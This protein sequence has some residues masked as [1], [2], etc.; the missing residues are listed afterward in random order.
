MRWYPLLF[1]MLAACTSTWQRQQS[2]LATDEADEQ[3]A[4]AAADARWLIDNAF[5]EAPAADR[6]PSAEAGRYL[7]LAKLSAKAGDIRAAVDALRHALRV[8]PQQGAAVRAELA[9]LPLPPAQLDRLKREFAWNSAALAPGDDAD[10]GPDHG[11][12]CWSYRVHEVQ[13][14][15]RRTLRTVDGLQRQVTYDARPWRFD[16]DSGR[17]QAEGP[18]VS[19]AGMEIE[20]VDGPEQPRYRATATVDHGFLSDDRVPPCHRSAWQ[21]PYDTG[22]TVFVADRLPSAEAEAP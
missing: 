3:Y 10:A 6:L 21:G 1:V 4:E 14:R 2:R 12:P 5:Y 20:M 17:W 7:H 19:D 8:D 22:G 9:H 16:A 15:H 11:S 13:I 18:W